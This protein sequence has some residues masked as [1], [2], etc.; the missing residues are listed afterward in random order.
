MRHAMSFLIVGLPVPDH[1]GVAYKGDLGMWIRLTATDGHP[2]SFNSKH[3]VVLRDHGGR[4]LV[5]HCSGEV[6]V[7]ESQ[8]AILAALRLRSGYRNTGMGAG[9]PG[10]Q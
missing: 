4:T 10:M 5:T 9:A 3:L 1:D 7:E 2:I 8:T 6:L